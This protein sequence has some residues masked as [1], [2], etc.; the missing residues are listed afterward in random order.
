MSLSYSSDLSA[1]ILLFF[2][3]AIYLLL[4]ADYPRTNIPSAP[5]RTLR[6]HVLDVR[7]DIP[8]VPK[9]I[10][11]PA[12]TV[13]IRMVCRL[14][15]RFRSRGQRPFIYRVTVRN[16]YVKH[17]LHRLIRPVGLTHLDHC[18]ANLNFGM[19]YHAVGRSI[20]RQFLRAEGTLQESDHLLR[21]QR[22]HVHIH[23][24]QSL[25]HV[26]LALVRGD[27]PEVA[28]WILHACAALAVF[29]IL[30]LAD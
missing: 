1:G 3:A 27:I 8:R 16:V 26:G 22:M 29:V 7:G 13:A 12:T 2:G 30:R 28:E 11:N 24:V 10:G 23:V 9:R 17:R 6:L 25:R 5:G 4:A 19:M 18:I 20:L 21:P 15:N 14:L